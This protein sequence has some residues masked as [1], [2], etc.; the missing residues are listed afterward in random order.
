MASYELVFIVSPEVTDD[1]ITNSV[2]KVSEM[3]GQLGGSVTEVSHWG[4]KKFTYPIKRFTEGNYVL[5]KVELAPA[6]IKK[7]D[8]NLR[9]SG[10]V[11]RHLL[12]RAV[13]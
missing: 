7:L 3:I 11:L 5:A 9:M 6:S 2:N 12:V 8:S 13:G 1:E 4:K 10:E